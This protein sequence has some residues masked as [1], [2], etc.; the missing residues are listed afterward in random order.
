[1]QTLGVGGIHF[2]DRRNAHAGVG[3]VRHD[4]TDRLGLAVADDDAVPLGSGRV[5]E[6]FRVVPTPRYHRRGVVR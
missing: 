1:M 6:E 3:I 4:Q 2:V 5:T